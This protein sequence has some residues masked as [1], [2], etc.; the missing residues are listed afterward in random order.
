MINH[1]SGRAVWDVMFEVA[2]AGG[3]A[4]LPIGCPTCIRRAEQREH[5]PVEL[6]ADAVIVQSGEDLLRV[7]GGA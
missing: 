3:Y 1:A 5:L 6:R 2:V 4:V 7:V